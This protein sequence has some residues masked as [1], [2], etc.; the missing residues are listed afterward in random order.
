M[1]SDIRKVLLEVSTHVFETSAFMA[2]YPPEVT[3]LEGGFP[4]MAASIS[5]K[6]PVNGRLI[7]AVSPEILTLLATSMLGLDFGDEVG[8]DGKNDALLEVLNMM[9][10]NVLTGIHGSEPVFDLCPPELIPCEEAQTAL[11]TVPSEYHLTFTVE[12]TRA[13]LILQTEIHAAVGSIS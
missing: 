6:G 12:D 8:E 11:A 1:T 13:D 7:L 10:G 4:P 9:C 3:N 5:F 2:V